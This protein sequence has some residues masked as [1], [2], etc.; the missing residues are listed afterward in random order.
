MG[1][2]HSHRRSCPLWQLQEDRDLLFD[3]SDWTA[4][5]GASWP[6]AVC[7][8]NQTSEAAREAKSEGAVL[9]IAEY[10][11]EI[12]MEAARQEALPSGM[13]NWRGL[14]AGGEH[15]ANV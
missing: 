2:W 5:A 13:R 6:G 7:F 14:A 4:H 11:H 12:L 15:A 8:A 10:L 1:I 9:E 3:V